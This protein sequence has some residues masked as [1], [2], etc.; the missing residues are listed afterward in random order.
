MSKQIQTHWMTERVDTEGKTITV[1]QVIALEDVKPLI[2][3][4]RW[5][6][7]DRT[8]Y[9]KVVD[10]KEHYINEFGCGCCANSYDVD[11]DGSIGIMNAEVDDVCGMKARDAIE[12]FRDLIK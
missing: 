4:L 5:Y 7:D 12:P 8:A 10:G 1:A 2:E 6:A 3:A 9:R 11:K